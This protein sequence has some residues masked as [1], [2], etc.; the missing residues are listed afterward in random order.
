MNFEEELNNI[1][2]DIA[3]NSVGNTPLEN[4]IVF[5][6]QIIKK[7]E[8]TQPSQDLTPK[9]TQEQA[10]A[11]MNVAS[12]TEDFIN[13]KLSQRANDLIEKD[14]KVSAQFTNLAKDTVQQSINTIDTKNKKQEKKNY[15]DLN[16]KD[17]ISLGGDK[18][19]T[20]GQ[21]FSIVLVKRFFWILFMATLGTFFI[22]PLAVIIELFQ[23]ISFKNVEKEEYIEGDNTNTRWIIKRHKLGTAGTIIGWIVG[24]LFWGGE[25]TLICF[26]PF[27]FMWSAVVIFGLLLIINLLSSIKWKN[28]PLHF[29]RK[30]QKCDLREKS[31]KNTTIEVEED[32]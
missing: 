4:N 3:K 18:T 8:S 1:K 14:D 11:I 12:N 15:F 24:L 13:V 9:M 32:I 17:V 20:Y 28:I 21:Q 25:I 27:I 26:F 29:K 23:G 5:N 16:E 22:A 19:S 2:K 30:K 7:E 10:N 31:Q 6:E